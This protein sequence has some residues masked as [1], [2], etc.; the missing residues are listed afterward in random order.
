MSSIKLLHDNKSTKIVDG[1]KIVDE[2]YLIIGDKGLTIKYY[3]REGEDTD[4]LVIFKKDGQ[5]FVKTGSKDKQEEKEISAD[6]LIKLIGKDKRLKFAAEL[7]KD[8]KQIVKQEGGK[9]RSKRSK[10]SKKSKKSKGSKKMAW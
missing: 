1:K 6:E 9:K 8:I 5:Y 3:H 2:E 7:L 4:K 10:K